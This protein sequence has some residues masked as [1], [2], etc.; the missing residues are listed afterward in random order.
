MASSLVL[1]IRNNSRCMCRRLWC[2]SRA[3]EPSDAP[4]YATCHNL[5]SKGS[6][7]VSG[8]QHAEVNLDFAMLNDDYRRADI[9][10]RHLSC[11]YREAPQLACMAATGTHLLALGIAA[12]GIRV[13]HNAR[14]LDGKGVGVGERRH[15]Q[16][17]CS[18]ACDECVSPASRAAK[19]VR[20]NARE[21]RAL[22]AQHAKAQT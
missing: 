11:R 5:T 20:A 1:F 22:Q 15:R 14:P 4:V 18:V 12:F 6:H 16:R 8:S 19:R 7:R 17:H 3:R 10:Q 9:R 2:S 21:Q 13:R